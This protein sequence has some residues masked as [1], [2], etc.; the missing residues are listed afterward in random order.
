MSE[1]AKLVGIEDGRLSDIAPTMLS[2][3][4]LEPSAETVSYTHLDVYK[5]QPLSKSALYHRVLRI[6]RLLN[7]G[8]L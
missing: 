6:E 5:R 7:G 3:A 1:S 4:G 8:E 2:M